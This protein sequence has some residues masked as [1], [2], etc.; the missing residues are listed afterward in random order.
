M[1]VFDKTHTVL[2]ILKCSFKFCDAKV[3]E[4]LISCKY[5]LSYFGTFVLLNILKCTFGLQR[6]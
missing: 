3:D 2:T 4:L 1:Y 5:S 6:M